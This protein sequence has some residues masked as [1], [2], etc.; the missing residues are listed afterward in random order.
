MLLSRV[1]LELK[2]YG[3]YSSSSSSSNKPELE[4]EQAPDYNSNSHC[5]C[6]KLELDSYNIRARVLNLS[7]KN[8]LENLCYPDHDSAKTECEKPV[9]SFNKIATHIKTCILFHFNTNANHVILAL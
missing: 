7:S 9:L 5:S 6:K 8:E 2:G 3:N 1:E 4:L